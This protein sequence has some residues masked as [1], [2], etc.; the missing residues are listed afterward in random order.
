MIYSLDSGGSTLDIVKWTSPPKNTSSKQTGKYLGSHEITSDKLQLSELKKIIP[1]LKDDDQIIVTGGKTKFWQTMNQSSNIIKINELPAIGYGGYDWDFFKGD[2]GVVVS[3]GTG[4]CIVGVS[5]AASPIKS[6]IPKFN[7][8][9]QSPLKIKHLGGTGIGGGTFLALCKEM[10]QVTEINEIINL[11][12]KGDLKNVDLTV[13]DIIGK[14][15]GKI[16][17]D[18][19]AANLGKIARSHHYSKKDLAAGIINLIAQSIG[20]CAVMAARYHGANK[21]TLVGKLTQIEQICNLIAE[22][23]KIYGIKTKTPKYAPWAI[24]LGAGKSHLAQ[25]RLARLKK[26]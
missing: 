9:I 22:T 10:L 25:S 26:S 13:A 7:N 3:M 21:I 19:T 17:G 11:F 15:I 14:G 12:N 2:K 5:P 18:K 1:N 16:P 4:T 8:T 24:A 23:A 20:T 6:K